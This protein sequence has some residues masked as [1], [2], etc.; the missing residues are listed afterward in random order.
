MRIYEP[1]SEE[2]KNGWTTESLSQ[3]IEERERHQAVVVGVCSPV[4]IGLPKT[5]STKPVIRANN[6]YNPHKW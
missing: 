6:S 1:S 5:Y 3:Y 2:I 4:S